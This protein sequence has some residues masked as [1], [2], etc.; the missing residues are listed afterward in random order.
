MSISIEANEIPS[1][2]KN[3]V[4]E[5]TTHLSG[6]SREGSPLG[7]LENLASGKHDVS[8]RQDKKR[9]EVLAPTKTNE[10]SL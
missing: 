9:K 4:F 5:G 3:A 1:D 8:R 10:R 2:G 6:R 7:S